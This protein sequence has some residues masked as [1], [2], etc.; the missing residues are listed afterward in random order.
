MGLTNHLRGMRRLLAVCVILLRQ[1]MFLTPFRLLF[2]STDQIESPIS[3]FLSADDSRK[4]RA[5]LAKE[6]LEKLGPTYVK[7]GQ[8]LSI[9]P[10]LVPPDF[11]KEFKKLQDQ[12]APF[13]FSQVIRQFRT[14]LKKDYIGIFS[15]FDETPM[16]AASVAQVHRARLRTGEEVAVKVQRPG[17]QESMTSDLFIMLRFAH[18]IERFIPSLRKNRPVMLVQEFSRWTERELYFRQEGKHA[19]HFAYNF[20]NYPGV[21]IPKVYREYTTKKLLVMEHVRG[22]NIFHAPEQGIDKKAV[23]QLIADSM[24]KQIFI[25][26]F[27]HG[28]PHAGNI[29]LT[30]GNTIVYLDFGIVGYVCEDLQTWIFDILY[31]MS[32]GDVSRVIRSFMELCNVEEDDIDFAGYR[33]SMHEILSELPVYEE[34]GVPFSQMMERFLNT[35]LAYGIQIPQDFVLVSK[36]LTTFEGTCLSLDPDINI[37]EYLRSFVR[38]QV[39]TGL[40]FDDML[41]QLKAGPFEMRRLKRLV[42]KHGSRAVKFFEDPAVRITSEGSGSFANGGDAT[43]LNIAYGFIIAALILFAALLGNESDLEQWLRSFLHLPRLPI[44]SLLS[45]AGAAGLWL[46]LFLRNRPRK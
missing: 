25:D 9:R 35:S 15:E 34:S 20:K 16:A 3:T 37:V 11:C 36:A 41:K 38:K 23:A 40:D 21:R 29:L 7:F 4:S 32:V 8:F 6:T 22:V 18:L 45:L 24:L 27:F 46:S 14:E 19:L 39:T 30:E 28:D 2:S 42:F 12:V 13:P 5:E 10:D 26:G 43:G 44:L 1:R 31:G 17:I 33:R